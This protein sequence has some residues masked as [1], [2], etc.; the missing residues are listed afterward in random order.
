MRI[1]LIGVTGMLGQALCVEASKR[2]HCVLGI[3]R[4]RAE[5]RID[6]SKIINFDSIIQKN[7]PE[8]II[9]A[10]AITDLSYCEQHPDEAYLVNARPVELIADACTR[11]GIY[12]VQISTDHYYLNDS[13]KKHNENDPIVIVNEYARSKI[14]GEAF[15]LLH[16]GSLVLRTNLVGFRNYG[17]PTFI[18]WAIHSLSHSKLITLY[19]DY[20]TSSIDVRRFSSILL[21]LIAIKPS[22]VINLAS[23]QVSSKKELIDMLAIRLGLSTSNTVVGS[24]TNMDGPRRCNTLGLDVA[25]AERLLG[26][27]LPNTYKVIQSLAEEYGRF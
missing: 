1:L 5:L 4:N 12:Y 24:V 18:E 21:D 8:V 2:N 16:N 25:K 26:Y 22:G 20:Y 19:D 27:E 7:R 17:L 6:L 13:R 11:H 10:S 23:S 15:A 14:S 9:N 3:A